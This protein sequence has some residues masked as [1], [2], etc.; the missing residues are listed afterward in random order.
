VQ[1]S[2]GTKDGNYDLP[3]SLD[4][5]LTREKDGIALYRLAEQPLIRIHV[6]TTRMVHNRQLRRLRDRMLPWTLYA[7]TQSNLHVGLQKEPHIVGPALRLP[8][9]GGTL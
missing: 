3:G 7:D 9:K 6:V 8:E 1:G 4:R 5:V 2:D